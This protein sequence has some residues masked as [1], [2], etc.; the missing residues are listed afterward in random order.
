M[1]KLNFRYETNYSESQKSDIKDQ[2]DDAI[3]NGY[4]KVK[5]TDEVEV[6]VESIDPLNQSFEA[7]LRVQSKTIK[8]IKGQLN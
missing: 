5:P 6:I 1:N 4:V 8:I 7:V 3:K 2:I